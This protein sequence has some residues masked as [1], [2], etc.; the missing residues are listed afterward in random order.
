MN[1]KLN[2]EDMLKRFRIDPAPRVKRAVLSKYSERCGRASRG[3]NAVPFWRRSVPLYFA[4]GLIVVIAGL[5][6]FGGQKLSRREGSLKDS[7]IAMQDTL[8][9][10]AP[11]QQWYYAPSDIF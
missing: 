9:D 3:A 2:I 1:T 5:S 6:F 8:P 10:M 11:E 4:A 7:S